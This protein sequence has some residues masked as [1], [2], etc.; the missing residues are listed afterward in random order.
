[1]DARVRAWGRTAKKKRERKHFLRLKGRGM[2]FA[3][4][5]IKYFFFII[6]QKPL[7]LKFFENTENAFL[8]YHLR[9]SNK[10]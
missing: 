9:S 3:E 2:V 5:I 4:F 1:M 6:I 10:D 7:V 8:F